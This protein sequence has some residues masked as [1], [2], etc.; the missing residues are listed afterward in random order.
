MAT[1]TIPPAFPPLQ[2]TALREN[3]LLATGG[4]GANS[5]ILIGQDHLLLIDAKMTAATVHELSQIIQIQVGKPV[6]K[7][8]LTHGDIDHVGGIDAWPEPFVLISHELTRKDI[9]AQADRISVK[10]L[11]DVTFTGKHQLDFEGVAV[12]LIHIGPAH[13]GADT[14][15]LFP[16]LQ[17]AF[18]GDVLFF[19]REPLIHRHKG[20]SSAG[21]IAALDFL[22][23]LEV[24][25]YASGH[26]DPV[27]K[28]EVKQLRS[29][30]VQRREQVRALAAARSSWEDIKARLAIKDIEPPPGRPRFPSLAE[31]IYQEFIGADARGNTAP[32]TPV[33]TQPLAAHSRI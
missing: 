23:T 2:I 13:T 19:N 21:L 28:A 20:G 4:A 32:E 25:T 8:I 14:A 10:H 11:P 24:D 1:P 3:L 15:V 26:S 9:I 16:G 33:N 12:E 18:V 29:A 7:I 30:I 22:L 17:A 5:G 31:V 27:G 6:S